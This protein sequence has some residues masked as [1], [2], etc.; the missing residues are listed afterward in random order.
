MAQRSM[1]LANMSFAQN[2]LLGLI[3]GLIKLNLWIFNRLIDYGL[4]YPIF[5]LLTKI[6]II[7]NSALKIFKIIYS[8][9]RLII[10]KE[11][12]VENCVTFLNSYLIYISYA[13]TKS[14]I[15]DDIHLLI[16]DGIIEVLPEEYYP[17]LINTIDQ[18]LSNFV[19][20]RFSKNRKYR[21][22]IRQ[23]RDSR[24]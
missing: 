18:S 12:V 19:C 14:T 7:R 6:L 16:L 11:F 20:S 9:I 15:I 5:F 24:R 13:D 17:I 23:F 3:V 4:I 21:N 2:V 10:G 22:C 1:E 8:N